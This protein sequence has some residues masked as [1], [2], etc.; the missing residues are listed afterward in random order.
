MTKILYIEDNED[1]FYMLS[2]RLKR[3][4]YE[5]IAAPDGETGIALAKSEEPALILMDLSLPVI[6]GWEATRRLKAADETRHIH[7]IALSA[8]SMAGDREKALAAGCD[9]Y[10]TKPVELPRLLEKIASL[11]SRSVNTPR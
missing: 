11:L 2:N 10:D 7:V 3:R 4:G 1:N 8:H 5:L 6:D 9:E